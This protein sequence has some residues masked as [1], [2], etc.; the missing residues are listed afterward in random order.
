MSLLTRIELDSAAR[1][2]PDRISYYAELWVGAMFLR[3]EAY[4]YIRARREP[5]ASGLLYLALIGVLT[6]IASILGAATRYVTSPNADYIKNALLEHLQATP[7]YSQLPPNAQASLDSGFQQLWNALGS[8]LLGYPTTPTGVAM[9]GLSLITVPL[10]LVIGWLIYGALVRLVSRGWNPATTFGELLAA[11]ALANSPQLLMA[12]NLFPGVGV[13]GMVIGLWTFVLNVFAIRQA[14][15]TTTRRAIWGALFPS[16][17]LF[18]ILILLAA[19]AGVTL[20]PILAQRG[21]A[22]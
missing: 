8:T 6:A 22:R 15:Q 9:L 7:L 3:P 4:Q 10:G 14:Y 5:F 17:L 12:L 16:L 11:L 21:G 13:S 2:L 1:S 20:L 19:L 18:V